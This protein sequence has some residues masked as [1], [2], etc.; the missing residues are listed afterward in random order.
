MSELTFVHSICC[1]AIMVHN[2][3]LPLVHLV[4]DLDHIGFTVHIE[5]PCSLVGR[6]M[7]I[8]TKPISGLYLW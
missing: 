4:W 1:Y 5:L 8:L 3:Q 2:L 6:Y 7:L